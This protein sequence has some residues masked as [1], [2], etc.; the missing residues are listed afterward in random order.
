MFIKL[1]LENGHYGGEEEGIYGWEGV[2]YPCYER[3]SELR[4]SFLI[5]M[6]QYVRW[7]HMWCA[8]TNSVHLDPLPPSQRTPKYADMHCCCGGEQLCVLGKWSSSG[9]YMWCKI[10]SRR[11]TVPAVIYRIIQLPLN[12]EFTWR[13]DETRRGG[14]STRRQVIPSLAVS[15]A[16]HGYRGPGRHFLP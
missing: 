5:H 11:T 16:E 3:L 9:L 2:L 6:G 13:C 8:S 7:Q 1:G 10:L 15:W 4:V 12:F 14:R